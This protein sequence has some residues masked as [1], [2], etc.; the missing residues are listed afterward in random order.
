MVHTHRSI[1]FAMP[2]EHFPERVLAVGAHPDDLEL[3]ACGTL[4]K[5]KQL[6]SIVCMVVATDGSAGHSVI[7]PEELAKIRRREAE[8]SASFIE[9]EFDWMGFPDE[10]VTDDITTRMRFVDLIR[11]TRPD[12]IITHNPQDYHPDH[13]VISKL[14]FDASFVSSLAGITTEHP[15]HPGVPP[16]YYF[17]SINGINFEPTEF[18]DITR[19]F[20][21]KKE[22]LGCHKSQLKEF[23][24][25][26]DVDYFDMIYI[27]SRFRGLQCGVMYAEGFTQE[28]AYPR[29]HAWRLLP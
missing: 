3:M 28:R 10:L 1:R 9:G 17:D 6:G 21:M 2:D 22:M 25:H 13:R 8:L 7:P 5:F 19:T 20:E 27:Q 26:E 23:N 18:V 11:H 29:L 15:P 24:E 14:V 12:L 4:A 16:L